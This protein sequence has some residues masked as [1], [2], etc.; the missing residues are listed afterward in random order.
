MK[1]VSNTNPL[2]G[3]SKIGQLDIL[4]KLFGHIII[5]QTIYTEFFQNSTSPEIAYPLKRITVQNM[6]VGIIPVLIG[7]LM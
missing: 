3:L 2:I 6:N 1:V 5:P 7:D 4:E